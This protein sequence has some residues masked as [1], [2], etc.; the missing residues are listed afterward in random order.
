[1]TERVKGAA[2]L[3]AK[4]LDSKLELVAESLE[5]DE[6][7]SFLDH[8]GNIQ[9]AVCAAVTLGGKVLVIYTADIEHRID[10]KIFYA[11]EAA[12]IA[13]VR[14]VKTTMS[15]AGDTLRKVAAETNFPSK[16]TDWDTISTLIEAYNAEIGN[17]AYDIYN[18]I[19]AFYDFGV[20]RSINGYTT[21]NK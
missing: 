15:E 21:D 16:V 4:L 11:Q 3:L 1:M 9:H 10:C 2:D 20:E 12:E 14:T 6:S 7:Q 13:R 19:A 8:M 17:G 18:R 5:V